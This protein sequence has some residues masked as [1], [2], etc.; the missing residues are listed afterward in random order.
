MKF[1]RPILFLLLLALVILT[2][3]VIRFECLPEI[4]QHQIASSG[5]SSRYSTNITIDDSTEPPVEGYIYNGF[6]AFGTHFNTEEVHHLLS[7]FNDSTVFSTPFSFEYNTRVL[8]CLDEN[9]AVTH[10]IEFSNDG[11]F[12]FIAIGQSHFGKVD[13]EVLKSPED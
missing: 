1:P 8:Y 10:I 3:L 11:Y 9:E 13:P 6:W 2:G 5:I 4:I 7:V 12:H